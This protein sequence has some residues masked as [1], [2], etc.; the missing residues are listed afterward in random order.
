[1][2][3]SPAHGVINLLVCVRDWPSSD[4]DRKISWRLMKLHHVR[5]SQMKQKQNQSSTGP[6]AFVYGC[7]AECAK[8]SWRLFLQVECSCNST[9]HH[10]V[11]HF[12][13]SINYTPNSLHTKLRAVFPFLP[14]TRSYLCICTI[15]QTKMQI[16]ATHG[17]C[18]RF[19]KSYRNIWGRFRAAD[20][21]GFTG[22]E[23]KA[24]IFILQKLLR[25][26]KN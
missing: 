26:C 1:M 22:M 20:C 6:G 23:S 2:S 8:S 17:H 14:V 24:K 16:A 18:L 25:I 5:L 19:R 12:W 7:T 9:N 11:T 21:T 10:I 3:H 15:I 13:I 4:G